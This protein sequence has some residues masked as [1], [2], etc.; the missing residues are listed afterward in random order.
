MTQE[1]KATRA[2]FGETLVELAHEGF[3]VV[4][5][6]ADLSGSTTTKKFADVHPNRMFNVGI[7]EQNMIGVAAGFAKTGQI[8]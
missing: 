4:A 2:A 3:P 8:A 1:K 7:A 5:V 6:D